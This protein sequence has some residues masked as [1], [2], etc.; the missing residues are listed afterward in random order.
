MADKELDAL[1][2]QEGYKL[3]IYAGMK[4]G[5]VFS[6]K[7]KDELERELVSIK[8]NLDTSGMQAEM[9]RDYDLKKFLLDRINETIAIQ[10]LE[11]DM[12]QEQLDSLSARIEDLEQVEVEEFA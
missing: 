5:F 11:L 6:H 9:A 4:N 10:S 3:D 7:R 12:Y 1:R 8:A 2:L